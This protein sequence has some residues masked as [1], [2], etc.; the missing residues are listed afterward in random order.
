MTRFHSCCLLNWTQAQVMICMTLCLRTRLTLTALWYCS[1]LTPVLYWPE[2]CAGDSCNVIKHTVFEVATP[3]D[4]LCT[5]WRCAL[6]RYLTGLSAV[7]WIIIP[8]AASVIA[9]K[10]TNKR[11]NDTHTHTRNCLLYLDCTTKVVCKTP[12]QSR[13]PEHTVTMEQNIQSSC[14]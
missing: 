7:L 5:Q 12:T 3:T 1:L 6:G 8:A 9:P 14:T 13:I 2:L 4:T 11:T 10:R